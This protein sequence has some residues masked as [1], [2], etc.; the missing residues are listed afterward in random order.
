[1]DA[2]EQMKQLVQ[3]MERSFEEHL[4]SLKT[5]NADQYTKIHSNTAEIAEARRDMERRH[6]RLEGDMHA[7]REEFR[8]TRSEAAKR[9]DMIMSAVKSVD[10]KLTANNRWTIT[11][12]LTLMGLLMAAV[13]YGI[14]TGAAA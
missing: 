6:G 4:E 12:V 7:M 13:G 8:V 2:H 11:T 3:G 10:D 9:E 5:Q 14:I 1:M